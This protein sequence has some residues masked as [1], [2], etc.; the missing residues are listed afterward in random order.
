MTA[1]RRVHPLR[2]AVL[3]AGYPSLAHFAREHGLPP[4]ALTAVV[5]YRVLPYPKM[6]RICAEALTADEDD[7][8][9]DRR[10][11][12]GSVMSARDLVPDWTDEDEAR[13]RR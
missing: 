13:L 5:N 12:A 8:S 4:S 10:D 1:R 6:R 2:V 7:L 11:R 9:S 3:S